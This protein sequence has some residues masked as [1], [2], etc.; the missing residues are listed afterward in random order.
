MSS[1]TENQQYGKFQPPFW[2][3][4]GSVLGV[5]AW[6][7][8]IILYALYWSKGFDLFQNTVV[9]IAS[10][11]ITGLAIG[12][13]WI[14]WF[15]LS[16]AP[17]QWWNKENQAQIHKRRGT[18]EILSAGQRFGEAV[19]AV[20][21]LLILAFYLYH[22]VANTGFFTSKFGGWEMFAFYGS[23][24]LSLVPPIGR[25]VI[26]RRNPVRPVEA[27]CNLFFAFAS[28]WLLFVFPFNFAHFANALPGGIRFAL[29]WVTDDIAK[30]VLVL[31]FLGTLISAAVNIVKYLTFAPVKEMQ[32]SAVEK[33]ITA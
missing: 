18:N 29:S 33:A 31:V 24:L 20:I 9:A 22:Q 14:I 30:L 28:L 2:A 13:M 12:A 3:I 10:F 21:V 8:F 26:G 16:G 27:A 6:L 25:A 11:L 19:S 15:R 32:E 17:R 4:I 23:I 1:S 5:V 7:S